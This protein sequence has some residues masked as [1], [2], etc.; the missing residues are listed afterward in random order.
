MPVLGKEGERLEGSSQ[1]LKTS[2]F[3]AA[4]LALAGVQIGFASGYPITKE[5][6]AFFDPLYW[7]TLRA[8]IATVVFWALC[9][10]R[11]IP[12]RPKASHG[13]LVLLSMLGVTLNQVFFALGLERSTP[14]EAAFI[15]TS[16]PV[17][18]YLTALVIGNE[19]VD[20][21]R[22]V[23]IGTAIGGIWMLFGRP[24]GAASFF[25]FANAAVYGLYVALA[26]REMR[27]HH[28]FA[29]L[30]WLFLYGGAAMAL[31][32]AV[33]SFAGLARVETLTSLGDAALWWR[34]AY[35]VGVGTVLTYACNAYAAR[36]FPA[37]VIG[38]AITAQPLLTAALE[39][40]LYRQALDA[41]LGAAGALICG[42]VALSSLAA[43]PRRKRDDPPTKGK[44]SV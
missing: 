21:R 9:R 8:V 34:A 17:W 2:G 27:S 40:L 36:R 13:R 22:L 37:S 15:C 25:N 29:L 32:S 31:A 23:G 5:L 20:W 28:P 33:L 43:I 16:I 19:R 3:W 4:A 35:L 18:V 10:A 24:Q 1:D 7:S 12:L 11:G 39:R 30:F 14:T 42:G 26:W 44:L 41:R 6:L 38:V